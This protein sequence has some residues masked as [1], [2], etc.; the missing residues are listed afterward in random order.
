M[1]DK[2]NEFELIANVFGPLATNAP[3]SL[4]LSDDAAI[5]S[6]RSDQEVVVAADTIVEG[7]HF[8][9][10]DPPGTV[11][12]KALG[13][14]LSDLAAMGAS[15]HGYTLSA[16]WPPGVST[17][18]IRDFALGLKA[19]QEQHFIYLLGGDTVATPGPI[20]LSVTAF[21]LVEKGKAVRRSGAR[22]GDLL[23]VTGTLGDAALGL[24]LLMGEDCGHL[25]N[26]FQSDLIARYQQPQPRTTCSDLVRKHATS[27]IDVSDGLVADVAHL[28]SA[29]KVQI[30][31]RRSS[32]PLSAAARQVIANDHG[33]VNH[34]WGGG[35]DYELA[36]TAPRE[37]QVDKKI[38]EFSE[39][40]ITEIGEVVMADGNAGAV[41]LV[42]D[43]DNAIDVDTGG[44]RHF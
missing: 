31:I 7:V 39:V 10:E 32:I 5:I 19:M 27:A 6:P 15:P 2:L 44:F 29:S 13:V 43:N 22:P 35:D 9:P 40:P 25:S 14:N 30:V 41:T 3:G 38:A 36:F 12:V 18:W 20:C 21:G 4:N 8:R 16:A 11:G 37:S 24:R 23:Y 42:D 17:T 34:V 26:N 1:V 33:Q 28:A